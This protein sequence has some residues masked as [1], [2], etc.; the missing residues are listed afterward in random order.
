MNDITYNFLKFLDNKNLVD[1][2]VIDHNSDEGF[3]NRL[4]AQICVGKK[5]PRFRKLE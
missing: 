5:Y 1:F 4:R 3:I 2:N